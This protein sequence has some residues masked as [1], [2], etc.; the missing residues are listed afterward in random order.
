MDFV[1]DALL[2]GRASRALTVV[3]Q[4]SRWSPILET[5]L[6][7][8]GSSVAEALE[9]ANARHGKPRSITAD[10]GT[11]STSR[12][13]NEWAYRRGIALDFIRPGKPTE[14]GF[15][16]AFN[17]K[18]PDECLDAN[19][20]LS[21]EDARSKVEAWRVDYN[22]HRPHGSLGHLT[23]REYLKRTGT[24]DDEAAKS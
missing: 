16:E 18:L 14:N 24:E 7:M 5:A 23:A 12:A 4:W 11:E 3:D 20:F 22:E 15:I 1:H 10:H 17:G 21:I 13:L 19:Q 8:S 9:R 2:D 6:S